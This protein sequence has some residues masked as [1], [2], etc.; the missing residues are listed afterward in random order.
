[1]ATITS[2]NCPECNAVLRPAKPLRAGKSVKCPRCGAG[3]VVGGDEPA[4]AP[5]KPKPKPP[6]P[7]QKKPSS[8]L[9]PVAS[10]LPDNEDDEGGGGTYSFEGGHVEEAAPVRY[11][12]DTS[13]RDLR[14]P[15][16]TAVIDPSNKLIIAGVTGFLGWVAF[17]ILLI[18]PI[19][20]PLQSAE[21]KAK[22]KESKRQKEQLRLAMGGTKDPNESVN[23][24]DDDDASIF[25]LGDIDFRK[26]ADM[27]WWG[28]VLCLLPL[29]LGMLYSATLC[30]GAVKIQNLESRQW[31]I[32][33]SIMAI[34]PINCWGL[35]TVLA[36]VLNMG[37]D[38]M[39]EGFFKWIVLGFFLI[40]FWG[41]NV[42]VGIWMLTVLNKPEVIAGY[43]YVP[44]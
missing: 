13:I 8:G 3:F 44:D 4:P 9:T 42:A 22:E 24:S 11:E 10:V 14:G 35:L 23:K 32:A 40:I 5:S 39:F 2:V 7:V 25:A 29:V 28:I 36:L 19:L 43:E 20:F 38:M 1:M 27:R 30:M 15:A 31:G 26:I 37:L 6:S 34:V 21:E 17:L 41:I 12:L 33:S 16:M 18:I